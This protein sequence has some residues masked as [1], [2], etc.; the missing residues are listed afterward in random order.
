MR[1]LIATVL[2]LACFVGRTSAIEYAF[3]RVQLGDG[4]SI[5]I[6]SHWN[7]LLQ[8]TR[9]N[10]NAAG[11]A[12]TENAKIETSR[13]RKETLLAVN[14]TPD[15]TGA[16][17]RVSITIPPDYSQQDLRDATPA[18]LAEISAELFRN[19]RKMESAGGPKIIQMQAASIELMGNYNVLVM[20]YRRNSKFGPS[21]WQVIQYKIP[22]KHRL[23]EI[24]LSYRES[25]QIVWRPILTKVKKSIRL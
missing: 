7:V 5:E 24:T 3:K 22:L 4:L 18:D 17:I 2:L 23:I 10:L 15:P 25:D 8:S 9:R 14:A 19:F 11:E 20:P 13:G 6:P 16:M 1:L 21:P 12:I